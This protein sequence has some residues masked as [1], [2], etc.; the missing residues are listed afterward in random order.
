[1]RKRSRATTHDVSASRLPKR[2]YILQPQQGGDAA[3]G[4]LYF[5][6]TIAFESSCDKAR[7]NRNVAPEICGGETEISETCHHGEG[8]ISS[9]LNAAIGTNAIQWGGKGG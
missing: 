9:P 2:V 3:D 6:R 4:L 1:M 7:W 8:K 5:F